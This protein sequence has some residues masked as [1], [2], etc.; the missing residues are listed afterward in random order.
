MEKLLNDFTIVKMG[1]NSLL[2]KDKRNGEFVGITRDLFNKLD[3]V[4]DIRV[5]DKEHDG[6]CSKW[7]EGRYWSRF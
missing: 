6:G 5:V 2:L 3:K 1:R 4:E 7:V